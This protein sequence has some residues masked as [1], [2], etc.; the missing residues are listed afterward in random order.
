MIGRVD[1][2]HLLHRTEGH[3]GFDHRVVV[4]PD[5]GSFEEFVSDVVP[6]ALRSTAEAMA[7]VFR[8]RDGLSESVDEIGDVGL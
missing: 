2:L 8:D 7:G 3:D 4:G 5:G 1:A 6:G